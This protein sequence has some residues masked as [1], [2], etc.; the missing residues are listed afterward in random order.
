MKTDN[1]FTDYIVCDVLGHIN[2]IT[3]KRMFSGIGLFLDGIIF[4]FITG[5]ELYFKC[6][7]KLKE[8]YLNDDCHIFNYSRKG[9][10]VK[11]GYISAT[12]DM[13]ENRE[14]ITERVY[15]SYELSKDKI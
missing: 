12:A 2:G 3:T 14:Y 10:E 4:G 5:G 8:K 6:D 9:K 15:E 7:E 1:S 11:L 13:L